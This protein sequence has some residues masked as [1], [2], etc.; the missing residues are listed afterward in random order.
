[1]IKNPENPENSK[2]VHG[3]SH[4]NNFQNQKFIKKK[5]KKMTL[6]YLTIIRA[7]SGLNPG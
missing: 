6:F 7:R 3:K 5:K 1:M 2:K 4:L